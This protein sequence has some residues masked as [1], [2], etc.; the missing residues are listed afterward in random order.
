MMTILCWNKLFFVYYISK[1]KKFNTIHV[2]VT[3]KLVAQGD[4]LEKRK[5]SK[6][7]TFFSFFP[8]TFF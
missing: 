7:D 3:F 8:I 5:K 6:F 2:Q 1:F 4:S